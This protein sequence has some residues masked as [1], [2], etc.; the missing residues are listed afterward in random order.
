M[1]NIICK[2]TAIA[3]I[4]MISLI[5]ML[6][7]CG[8]VN[9]AA[10]SSGE[11]NTSAAENVEKPQKDRP[12]A[13]YESKDGWMLEYDAEIISCN[14]YHE[15]TG[16]AYMGEGI[17]GTALI[18]ISYK[19]EKRPEEV[20]TETM[21]RWYDKNWTTSEG[22]FGDT[23]ARFCGAEINS[24]GG[25][26]R[27]NIRLAAVELGGGTVLIDE[28]WSRQQN[29][30]KTAEVISALENLIDTFKFTDSSAK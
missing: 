9:T 29:D 13:V 16:F 3:G 26:H 21:D 30:E 7:G 18:E 8:K 4:A 23:G 1:K 15:A 5:L 22:I 25:D 24:T 19:P 2:S 27:L 17:T 14:E 20:L 11:G 12:L 28:Q 6:S 10:Y